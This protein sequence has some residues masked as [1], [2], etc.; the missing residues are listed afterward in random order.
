MNCCTGNETMGV[1]RDGK[2]D[3]EKAITHMYR[4]EDAAQAFEDFKNAPG[5]CL[6]VMLDFR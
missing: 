5:K 4:F 3:V 1:Q 6:K 2:V